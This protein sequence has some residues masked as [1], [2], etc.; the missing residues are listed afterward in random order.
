MHASAETPPIACQLS[1][2]SDPTRHR[3]LTD[4]LRAAITGCAE[5]P[6]GYSYSLKG[7]RMSLAELGRWIGLERQCCPF[8]NFELCV[9]GADTLW[10]LTLTGP[11]GTKAILEREFPV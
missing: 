6:D 11:E 7:E 5:L 10:W 3:T 8:L 1:A 4:R 2:V 9:S